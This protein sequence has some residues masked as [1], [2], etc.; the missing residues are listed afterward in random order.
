MC[1]LGFIFRQCVSNDNKGILPGLQGCWGCWGYRGTDTKT[2]GVVIADALSSPQNYEAGGSVQ[3]GSSKKEPIQKSL[4]VM[5]KARESGNDNDNDNGNGNSNDNGKGNKNDNG[6]SNDNGDDNGKSSNGNGHV[7]ENDFPLTPSQ[8]R[9][10]Q[11]M[12]SGNGSGTNDLREGSLKGGP[13]KL[14]PI[15][16][17][18]IKEG[19]LQEG[20]LKGGRL[21]GA[22]IAMGNEGGNEGVSDGGLGLEKGVGGGGG[23]GGEDNEG[24]HRGEIEMASPSR[25]NGSNDNIAFP[26]N[27]QVSHNRILEL[28][29]L[30]RQ[31]QTN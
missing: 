11:S 18:P 21:Q 16:G 12:P 22:M 31:H 28:E 15:R 29:A 6:N 9:P 4:K 26:P 1:L 23:G 3:E 13:L 24:R 8:Q 5:I 2:R 14:D 7:D 20:S 19:R 30:V 25:N 10:F 17:G 27:E